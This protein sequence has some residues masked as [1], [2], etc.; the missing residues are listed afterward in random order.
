MDI[1]LVSSNTEDHFSIL[2]NAEWETVCSQAYQRLGVRSESIPLYYKLR[3][4]SYT[5]E[6]TFKPLYGIDDWADVMSAVTQAFELYE[7]IE[8]EILHKVR[9][10]F[11]GFVNLTKA[12]GHE[13][14]PS[15]VR[16]ISGHRNLLF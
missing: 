5:S 4:T 13:A 11:C 6:S 3:N 1:R 12:I 2:S 16:G 15:G 8:L 10:T 7:D 14:K 9:A